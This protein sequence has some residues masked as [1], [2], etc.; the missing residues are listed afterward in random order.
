[1]AHMQPFVDNYH[2]PSVQDYPVV[3][4]SHEGAIA[5]C[6]WATEKI[7]SSG[8]LDYEVSLKLPTKKEWQYASKTGK[9]NMKY[10]WGG[11]YI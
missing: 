2:P 5:Y 4:V 9:D 3:N 7:N 6:E 10:S 8:L 1:M 11:P